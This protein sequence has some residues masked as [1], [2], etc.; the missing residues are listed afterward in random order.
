[1]T[2]RVGLRKHLPVSS[3][4]ASWL[5]L[6]TALRRATE[7]FYASIDAI[8]LAEGVPFSAAWYPVFR[9]LADGGAMSVSAVAG[10]IGQSHAAVSQ[11]SK[12][13]ADA[14]YLES[15]PARDKRQRTLGLSVDGRLM[16]ARLRDVW[17]AMADALST[18]LGAVNGDLLACVAR[19]HETLGHDEL[20]AAVLLSARRRRDAALKVIEPVGEHT[21]ALKALGVDA[22]AEGQLVL[23]ARLHGEV[24]GACV[25]AGGG[26]RACELKALVV[27]PVCR[28]LGVGRR[29]MA[30][31][32][33]RIGTRTTVHARCRAESTAAIAVLEGL[34]FSRHAADGE[35]KLVLTQND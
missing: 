32:L 35:V 28:R 12:K 20:V 9:A 13:L 4:P 10:R 19:M 27:A 34:G 23:C 30:A 8:Y 29:L 22:E 3:D 33:E 14:G 7:R 5:T 21:A 16:A 1:M 15:A 25:L 2:A 31:M 6:G 11:V 17:D 26:D 18:E 24:L